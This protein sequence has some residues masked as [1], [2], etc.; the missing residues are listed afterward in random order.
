MRTTALLFLPNITV[1]PQL[2][3]Q[4]PHNYLTIIQ[5]GQCT[6]TPV[7]NIKE[8]TICH[9]YKPHTSNRNEAIRL[10]GGRYYKRY[11]TVF[12]GSD[13]ESCIK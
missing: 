7:C 6:M 8:Q 11:S 3:F 5:T 13:I 10:N 1:F 12:N 2:S 4:L 9:R